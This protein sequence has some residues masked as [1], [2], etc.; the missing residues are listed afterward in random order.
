MARSVLK[1]SLSR[2]ERATFD[3]ILR[4]VAGEDG[5][6][7]DRGP[8][9]LLEAL[10][11][12][13]LWIRADRL[14]SPKH[15]ERMQGVE[16]MLV[17]VAERWN[18]VD[19]RGFVRLFFEPLT[20]RDLNDRYGRRR[21]ST[22]SARR[23]EIYELLI[24]VRGPM[25]D[26]YRLP[27]DGLF[28]PVTLLTW[29]HRQA[30]DAAKR[31]DRTYA[32][33]L[34]RAFRVHLDGAPDQGRATLV[35]AE[36]LVRTRPAAHDPLLR[37]VHELLWIQVS[38]KLGH[39]TFGP[40]LR[41]EVHRGTA[42]ENFSLPDFLSTKL[43]IIRDAA[44]AIPVTRFD[45][46]PLDAASLAFLQIHEQAKVPGGAAASIGLAVEQFQ[47]LARLHATGASGTDRVARMA[48]RSAQAVESYPLLARVESGVP[49]RTNDLVEAAF[50]EGEDSWLRLYFER[51]RGLY[52]RTLGHM[53]LLRGD[54]V[55]AKQAASAGARLLFGVGNAYDGSL[56]RE[57]EAE[58]AGNLAHEAARNGSRGEVLAHILEGLKALES[59]IDRLGRR[60][61]SPP[62]LRVRTL[63]SKRATWL[64]AQCTQLDLAAP[65][66]ERRATRARC[67]LATDTTAQAY[68]ADRL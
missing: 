1:R 56:A 58:A 34:H 10:D 19:D 5:R 57:I 32:T 33:L 29:L 39:V 37:T 61:E 59:A 40:T 9:K 62:L 60:A 30:N 45:R 65:V 41:G 17:K 12:Q 28:E 20:A 26:R 64:V 63:L 55:G 50:P 2:D 49:P 22:P 6:V 67:L 66:V 24:A 48:A 18:R 3:C 4:E 23:R 27:D 46:R 8:H 35:R 36:H 47:H 68:T 38:A 31:R 11:D 13:G 54:W 21:G 14:A 7:L 16:R 51:E 44:L 52:L 53:A 43:P 25:V 42:D 15:R